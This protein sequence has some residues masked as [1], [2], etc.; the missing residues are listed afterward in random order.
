[1]RKARNVANS[2]AA[3]AL[4]ASGGCAGLHAQ[5]DSIE[6]QQRELNVALLRVQD[7]LLDLTLRS[8]AVA[9]DVLSLQGR[10][11]Q[12]EVETEPVLHGFSRLRER[13]EDIEQRTQLRL[14][15]LDR[16]QATS[17]D[18]LAWKSAGDLYAAAMTEIALGQV[19]AANELLGQLLQRWPED[20]LT[21]N[22]H[23]ALAVS[24]QERGKYDRAADLL[25]TLIDVYPGSN[26]VNEAYLRLAEILDAAGEKD[27][28]RRLRA[29]QA[30]VFGAASTTPLQ[31][32][33]D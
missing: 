8:Q 19:T 4:L 22:A 24:Y 7:Q 5:L 12:L 29:E 13:L 14:S 25:L 1:M 26:L 31:G 6:R 21:A 28:A 30:G 17:Y 3:G 11:G 23:Y 33:A 9:A 16:E 27:L 15:L 10:V 18:T 32:V 2:L 20:E